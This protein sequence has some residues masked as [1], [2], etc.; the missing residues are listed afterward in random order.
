[1]QETYLM[2]TYWLVDN[3]VLELTISTVAT[4]RYWRFAPCMHVRQPQQI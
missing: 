1:M 2:H 3:G 4:G